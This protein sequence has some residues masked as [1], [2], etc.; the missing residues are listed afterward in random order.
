M[1]VKE[2]EDGAI[3]AETVLP[4]TIYQDEIGQKLQ[5][6]A[7]SQNYPVGR[8]KYSKVMDGYVGFGTDYYVIAEKMPPIPGGWAVSILSFS[9]KTTRFL[10]IIS[11]KD[12]F[13]KPAPAL[14]FIVQ[15]MEEYKKDGLVIVPT[16]DYEDVYGS[17][18]QYY[19]VTGHPVL[20][21]A[22]EEFLENMR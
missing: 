13:N 8:V 21:D 7:A 3:L 5:E 18:A 11:A 15:M 1:L 20:I 17:R 19:Q 9:P 16:E 10:V 6:Y 22:L 4:S 14:K 12:D 2:I